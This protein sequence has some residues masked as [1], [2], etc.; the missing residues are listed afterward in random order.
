V[1]FIDQ[2]E[3]KIVEK[4]GPEEWIVAYYITDV[5]ALKKAANAERMSLGAYVGKLSRGSGRATQGPQK[6]ASSRWR[7]FRTGL[8]EGYTED[9]LHGRGKLWGIELV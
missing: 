7:V 2:L 1:V 4:R 5:E 9:S 6:L 3:W 8:R